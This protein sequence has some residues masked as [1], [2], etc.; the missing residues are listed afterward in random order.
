MSQESK[1]VAAAIAGLLSDGRLHDALRLLNGRVEHR[2]TGIYRFDAPTLR[3][4]AL[5]DAANPEIEVGAPAPL[6]ETYCSVV[7]EKNTAFQTGDAASDP[8]LAGHPARD[9]TLAYCGA[10]LRS[11]D[12]KVF[13]TLCHFDVVPRAIPHDEV[14]VLETVAALIA[15]HVQT[16]TARS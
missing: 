2:F 1:E 5:F 4:I 7:G 3:N 6:R 16:E 13:G 9:S 14:P 11:A 15:D 12:G 8:Q 10:P